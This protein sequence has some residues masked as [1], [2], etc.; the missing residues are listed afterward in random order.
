MNIISLL[1]VAVVN[2]RTNMATAPPCSS[3]SA[4]SIIQILA[5]RCLCRAITW[6]L[7]DVPIGQILV[8]H[9]SM[10]RHMSGSTSVPFAAVP[11]RPALFEQ[12]Q[13]QARCYQSS[14]E[15]TR[16]FCPTCGSFV[17]MEYH[18]EPATLWIPMGTLDE[19]S[20]VLVAQQCVDP[21][22]DSHIM[23]G[24]ELDPLTETLAQLQRAP[25]FGPY[26][27]DP[28]RGLDDRECEPAMCQEP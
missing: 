28:C 10:C 22:R 3:K 14:K 12:L 6:T 21:E 16:Y 23:M 5:G 11:R 26:R 19:A 20:A 13:L 9:C 15:A 24:Q 18:H 1:H 17:C 27:R 25:G 2:P 7:H 4:R 8:C